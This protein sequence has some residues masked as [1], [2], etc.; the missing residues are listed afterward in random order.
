ML[1]AQ[2]LGRSPISIFIPVHLTRDI[3]REKAP[4]SLRPNLYVFISWLFEFIVENI[5]SVA[6]NILLLKY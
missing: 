2:L 6:L 1:C 4:S 3:K 5:L